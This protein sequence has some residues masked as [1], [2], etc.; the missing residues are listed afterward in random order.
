MTGFMF[1]V[2]CRNRLFSGDQGFVEHAPD[3]IEV[4]AEVIKALAHS[5]VVLRILELSVVGNRVR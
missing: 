1:Y 2:T 4:Y 5:M 3:E